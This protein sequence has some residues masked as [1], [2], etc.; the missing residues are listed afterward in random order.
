MYWIGEAFAMALPGGGDGGGGG[1][2]I[3]SLMPLFF[4]VMLFL[5]IRTWVW[6]RVKAHTEAT[7]RRDDDIAK[8]SKCKAMIVFGIVLIIAGIV[9]IVRSPVAYLETGEQ[10][11]A[12]ALKYGGIAGIAVGAVLIGAG[13][14][15]PMVGSPRVASPSLPAETR[16][17]GATIFCK[18]C[19]AQIAADSIFCEKCGTKVRS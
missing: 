14:V 17:E 3:T 18:S 1:S 9:A 16:K 19:G 13:L 8:S 6:P 10:V 2:L 15:G 4:L 7:E 5:A 11:L 12:D